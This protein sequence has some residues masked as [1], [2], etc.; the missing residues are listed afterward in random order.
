M[1]RYIYIFYVFFLIGESFICIYLYHTLVRR[2]PS[3]MGQKLGQKDRRT[4]IPSR[5]CK[6]GGSALAF[7]VQCRRKNADE[8]LV[9][10]CNRKSSYH[11]KYH[12]TTYHH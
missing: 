12:T 5:V 2:T 1:A 6:C 3:P 4:A 8:Y 11:T 10:L 7:G 9:F